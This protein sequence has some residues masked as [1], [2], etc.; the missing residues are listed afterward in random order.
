MAPAVSLQGEEGQLVPCGRAL[1]QLADVLWV[2]AALQLS[3]TEA[4]SGCHQVV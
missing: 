2:T 3:L 4:G 1:Q